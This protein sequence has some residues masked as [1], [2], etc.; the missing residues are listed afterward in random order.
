MSDAREKNDQLTL[1]QIRVLRSKLHPEQ[2]KKEYFML[3][4]TRMNAKR[5]QQY[6]ELV[7]MDKLFQLS[8]ELADVKATR[9]QASRW[10]R[11]FGAAWNKR[12]VAKSQLQEKTA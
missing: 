5:H 6:K 2:R 3:H 9:R 10:R 1:G 12:N 8:C 4:Q 7:E 11:R